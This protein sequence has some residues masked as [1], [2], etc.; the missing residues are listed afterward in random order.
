MRRRDF[1]RMG[2][3]AGAPLLLRRPQKLF[4]LSSLTP[5]SL[6]APNF[7]GTEILGCPTDKSV[8]INAIAD[9]ALEVYFEY[10]TTPSIYTAQT[11]P[12]MFAADDPIEIVMDGLQANTRYYYRMR[13]RA[14]GSSDPFDAR[15]EYTFVTRRAPGSTFTFAVQGDSHPERASQFDA[16]LYTRTLHTVAADK[17][18]FYIMM[19]DDFSV[20]NLTTVTQS[21]V[22]GRYT[23]Q[24]PF[25]GL[26]GSCAPLFMVNGNHEQAAGYLLDG[27]PDN[28]AVW[29]QNARNLYY[30]QPAPN[31]FYTG[32][33]ES[34]EHIGLLE[35]YFAWTWGDALFVVI[36]PYWSSSVPVDNVFGG[37]DKT[38][39][40]WLITHDNAQYQWFKT[41]L[42][43]SS[44]KY[45][46]V[47]THQ[48]LGTRR[49]GIELA[50]YYEW[51]GKNA[52]GTWGFT[53]RRP[54]WE[55]PIHQL[56]AENNVTIFFHGHDHIFVR[57]ELDGVTY[58]ELPEPADPNYGLYN[59]DRY[60]SGVKYPNS[61]YVRVTVS[62]S[63]VFV[64]YVRTF[65][66]QDEI[67]PTK[68]HGMVQY[69]YILPETST[70][71][72]WKVFD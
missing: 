16:A 44:A 43:E 12:A 14:A 36:D 70:V 2:A 50:D 60:T 30:P 25:L 18:D 65:L 3:F 29:A 59:A 63:S 58:Q 32:N 48:A 39:D 52:D 66:P 26:V 27:T 55:T 62:E 15:D 41:T 40:K 51:G 34:V 9:T 72:S 24:R 38:A 7:T 49:G 20:D 53:T 37:G 46:F 4:A 11:T 33:T 28:V 23:L 57:Q 6:A 1:L 61:G 67:P 69:S 19:G 13:H 21:T 31:D 17:P 22:A 71:T 54:G 42:E 56:M 68:I 35:N 10:G 8:R 45:K 47:F 64:E 5:R